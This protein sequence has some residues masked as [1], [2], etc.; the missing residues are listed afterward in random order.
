MVVPNDKPLTR[1]LA[2]PIVA[3]AGTV[4]DHVPPVT[5]SDSTDVPPRQTAVLPLIGAGITFTVIGYIA[6]QP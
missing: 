1:P 3:T 2:L 5:A 4:L 6:E